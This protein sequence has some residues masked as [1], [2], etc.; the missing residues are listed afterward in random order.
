[1]QEERDR[2]FKERAADIDKLQAKQEAKWANNDTKTVLLS[3]TPFAYRFSVEYANGYL[4]D[5]TPPGQKPKEVPSYNEGDARDQFFMS[6]FGYRMRTNKLTEPGDEVDSGLLE[7]EFNQRL[8]ASGAMRARRLEVDQDYDRRFQLISDGIDGELGIGTQIDAG[9]SWLSERANRA[10]EEARNDPASSRLQEEATIWSALN[11]AVNSQFSYLQRA[12]LLESIKARASIDYVRAHL[13]RGRKVVVF[14]DFN[15]GGGFHPFH[16]N[17]EARE[18]LISSLGDAQAANTAISMLHAERPDLA[19]IDMSDLLAP[20]DRYE[21][22]FSPEEVA[23]VRGGISDQGARES[24]EGLQRR[25]QP[26]EGHSGAVRR[27]WRGYL[28]A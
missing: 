15:K 3:A 9:L 12:F 24:G 27:G 2:L 26:G 25:R 10:N 8:K 21:V 16:L 5:Y 1:M 13:D 22:S 28:A 17:R 18:K 20:I 19:A 11:D 7:R 4:F 6:N 23:A 14:H